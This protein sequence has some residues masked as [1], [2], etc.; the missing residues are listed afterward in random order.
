MFLGPSSNVGKLLD[1]KMLTD[2]VESDLNTVRDILCKN[3]D[4][5]NE[6]KQYEATINT[7]VSNLNISA[8]MTLRKYK[9]FNGTASKIAMTTNEERTVYALCVDAAN[10]S[11]ANS[12]ANASKDT[13]DSDNAITSSSNVIVTGTDSDD[14]VT[15]VLNKINEFRNTEHTFEV[16]GTFADANDS[17][18][19]G[20][21][22][23]DIVYLYCCIYKR[24]GNT[25]AFSRDR[26][27]KIR[28][29]IRDVVSDP[30]YWYD[31]YTAYLRDNDIVNY[32][33]Y[34]PDESSGINDKYFGSVLTLNE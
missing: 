3:T 34:K 30:L 18:I 16:R 7:V 20:R 27:R 31:R 11:I 21:F 6:L 19:Y 2:I 29:L 22:I 24:S 10:T 15:T 1:K 17:N 28:I 32:D 25:T 12:R 13:S 8:A 9:E 4:F 33:K 5:L 26:S 14:T 23:M